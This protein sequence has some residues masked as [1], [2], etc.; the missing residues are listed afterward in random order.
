[1]RSAWTQQDGPT[2][3]CWSSSTQVRNIRKIVGNMLY[4]LF[5]LQDKSVMILSGGRFL[6]LILDSNDQKIQGRSISGEC[7]KGSSVLWKPCY[8]V[9]VHNRKNLRNIKY[10]QNGTF[11]ESWATNFLVLGMQRRKQAVIDW[12]ATG[13][14]I[15]VPGQGARVLFWRERVNCLR[16]Q[17]RPSRFCCRGNLFKDLRVWLWRHCY[18][19]K[20]W[21]ALLVKLLKRCTGQ[22][23]LLLFKIVILWT[24][25]IGPSFSCNVHVTRGCQVCLLCFW[26]QCRAL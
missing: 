26:T 2:H 17:Y 1:M 15:P 16:T 5:N 4:R 12:Y 7:T 10:L 11:Y 25:S 13:R 9:Q 6:Q 22:W 19:T 3:P 8:Y 14:P 18:D 24:E 20:Q 21:I 23:P